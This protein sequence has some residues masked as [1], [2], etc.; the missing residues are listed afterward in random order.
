MQIKAARPHRPGKT[1]VRI[2]QL[3]ILLD[4]F[5]VFSEIENIYKFWVNAAQYLDVCVG[6]NYRN[7]DNYVEH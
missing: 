6:T 1:R 4:N 5:L 3:L 7:D 2:V